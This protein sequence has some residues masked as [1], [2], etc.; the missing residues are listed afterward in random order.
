MVTQ[1]SIRTNSELIGQ[2]NAVAAA[3]GRT[4]SYLINQAMEEYIAREAWQVAEIRKA[5]EEADA[6][7]FVPDAEMQIFWDR[8]AK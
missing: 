3:T 4:R 2:F 7:K 8:W 5:L 1:V 6:G